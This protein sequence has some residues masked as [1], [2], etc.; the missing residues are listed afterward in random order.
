VCAALGPALAACKGDGA[1]RPAPYA[2]VEVGSPAP[3][4]AARALAGDSLSFGGSKAEVTLL[5]VWATWC[6]SCREE[7]AELERLRVAHEVRG[8]RVVAVSVDQGGDEKVRRFVDAQGTRFPVA[9]DREARISGLYGVVGLPATYLI[10]RDGRVRW[11]LTGSF[12]PALATLEK[13]IEAEL[14]GAENH[15]GAPARPGP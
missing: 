8:L 15:A 1:D 2:Q 4:Y 10:G 6:A 5:N 9:H 13:A 14:A 3:A 11:T 12:L 7:F